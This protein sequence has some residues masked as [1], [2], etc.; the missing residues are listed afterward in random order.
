LKIIFSALDIIQKLIYFALLFAI[1]ANIFSRV[2]GF[3][4]HLDAY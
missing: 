4:K 3:Q 2:H 1:S